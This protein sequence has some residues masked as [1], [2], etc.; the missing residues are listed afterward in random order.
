MASAVGMV[1]TRNSGAISGKKFLVQFLDISYPQYPADLWDEPVPAGHPH[2]KGGVAS[3]FAI[4][5]VVTK[6]STLASQIL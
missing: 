5:F 2:L 1:D 4:C 6:K 3:R